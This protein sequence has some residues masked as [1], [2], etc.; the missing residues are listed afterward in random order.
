M[1]IAM[2]VYA[3]KNLTQYNH[4]P[5]LKPQTVRTRQTQLPM[6]NTIKHWHQATPFHYSILLA[7][8]AFNKLLVVSYTMH[9]QSTRPFSWHCQQSP[10]IKVPP[11]KR[12]SIMSKNSSVTCECTLMKK[13]QGFPQMPPISGPPRHEV[14][15]RRLLHTW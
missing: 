13:I 11:L 7:R 4:P 8:N 10:H 15:Q 12:P 9:K 14:V 6:G 2:S 5:P 3:I 1:G